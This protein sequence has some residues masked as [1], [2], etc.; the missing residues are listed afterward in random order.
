MTSGKGL[1][2]VK[3]NGRLSMSFLLVDIIISGRIFLLHAFYLG[4]VGLDTFAS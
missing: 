3:D 1:V 2:Q 4:N